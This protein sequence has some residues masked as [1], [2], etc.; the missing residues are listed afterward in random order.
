M[1]QWYDPETSDLIL[2]L[3][4]V[5]EEAVRGGVSMLVRTGNRTLQIKVN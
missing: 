5:T 2:P 4:G 1:C 3:P